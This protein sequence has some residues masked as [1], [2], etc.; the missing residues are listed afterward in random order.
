MEFKFIVVLLLIEKCYSTCQSI[1]HQNDQV[2]EN[3]R[4]GK[5]KYKKL[6]IIY[7][8]ITE[9]ENMYIDI[10]SHCDECCSMFELYIKNVSDLLFLG[11]KCS[12]DITSGKIYNNLLQHK[13]DEE[14]FQYVLYDSAK[15]WIFVSCRERNYTHTDM[16]R[17]THGSKAFVRLLTSTSNINIGMITY[18]VIMIILQL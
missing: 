11:V 4:N 12:S 16:F 9:D 3:L 2:C 7:T 14:T 8:Q 15:Q 17:I 13:N 18:I 5:C 6:P 10:P 1:D